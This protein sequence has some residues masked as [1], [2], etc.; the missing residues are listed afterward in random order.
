MCAYALACMQVPTSYHICRL[1]LCMSAC[2]KPWPL[3]SIDILDSAHL[4]SD[5]F[6]KCQVIFLE[7]MT[8]AFHLPL[9]WGPVAPTCAPQLSGSLPLSQGLPPPAL[10]KSLDQSSCF[11]PAYCHGSFSPGLGLLCFAEGPCCCSCDVHSFLLF[12]PLWLSLIPRVPHN[13]LSLV[14]RLQPCPECSRAN[15]NCHF[16]SVQFCF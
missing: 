12:S 14:C 2:W 13:S 3:C 4:K 16:F 7:G 5:F 8:M 9:P 6:A 15:S 11:P 1:W 10:D